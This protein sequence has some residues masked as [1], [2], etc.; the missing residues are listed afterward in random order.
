MTDTVYNSKTDKYYIVSFSIE[1][2][3]NL[4]D[5]TAYNY[6]VINKDTDQIEFRT[7]S[8]PQAIGAAEQFDYILTNETWKETISQHYSPTVMHSGMM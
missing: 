4:E 1:D 6:G 2:E 5:G 7:D 8:L 3:G